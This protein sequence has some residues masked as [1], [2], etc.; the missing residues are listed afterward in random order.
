MEITTTSESLLNWKLRLP[1]C[2]HFVRPPANTTAA[3]SITNISSDSLELA[4]PFFWFDPA[5]YQVDVERCALVANAMATC[6]IVVSALHTDL[7]Q[8]DDVDASAFT[9]RMVPHRFDRAGLLYRDFASASFIDLRMAPTRDSHGRFAYPINQLLRWANQ[10][11]TQIDRSI[12]AMTFPPD[13]KSLDDMGHKVNQ[14]RRLSSAVV[15]LSFDSFHLPV[16]MPAALKAKVDGVIVQISGDPLASIVDARRM[17]D[18][19]ENASIPLW[20]VTANA[21]S[22]EDCVKCFAMGADGIAVDAMCNGFLYGSNQLEM[23]T[24]ER[25]ARSFGLPS[26]ADGNQRVFHLAKQMVERF[27]ADVCGRAHSCGVDRLSNLCPAHLTRA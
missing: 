15:F 22:A 26:A 21:L 10:K 27:V 6:G 3:T 19:G 11:E 16:M 20:I 18:E 1:P 13:W 5:W 8:N 2:D 24:S 23:T 12:D 14:L 17:I 25:A 4:T 9:P 7:S